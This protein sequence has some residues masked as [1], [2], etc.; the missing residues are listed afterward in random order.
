MTALKTS[1]AART[2]SMILPYFSVRL[3]SAEPATSQTRFATGPARVN[4]APT[5]ASS[6]NE[7]EYGR[8]NV[9]RA[10]RQNI[11]TLAFVISMAIPVF[12]VQDFAMSSFDWPDLTMI[13]TARQTMYRAPAYD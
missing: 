6:M 11:Q 12:T 2:M 10:V 13:I 4:K 1:A 5:F 7:L 8:T 9:P 3:S